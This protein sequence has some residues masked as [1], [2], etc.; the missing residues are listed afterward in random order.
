ML[1]IDK[2]AIIMEELFQCL[3]MKIKEL[4]DRQNRLKT[5]NE[6]LKQG[7]TLLANE[8]EVLLVKQKKA[9][10]QIES[11]VSRLKSIEKIP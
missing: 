1:S 4:I 8:K 7:K 10:I 6:E 9:I 5:S 2:V 11:L 3:E